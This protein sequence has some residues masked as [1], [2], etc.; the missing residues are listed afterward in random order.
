M[1]YLVVHYEFEGLRCDLDSSVP[2][3]AVPTS[4]V[5][6]VVLIFLV[7]SLAALF[8]TGI[9]GIVFKDYVPIL[10]VWAVCG[11]VLTPIV[12]RYVGPFD[13]WNFDAGSIG[14]SGIQAGPNRP[15]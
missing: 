12:K 11:P 2:P 8:G 14:K 3:P 13:G 4:A 9:Y 15:S 5:N 10:C 1:K 6:S 7:S